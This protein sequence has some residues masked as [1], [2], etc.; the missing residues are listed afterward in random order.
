MQDQKEPNSISSTLVDRLCP[1]LS[2]EERARAEHAWLA[3]V[4]LVRRI[5]ARLEHKTRDID[6]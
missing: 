3:Y 1:Q 2:E 5:L 4:T 6:F